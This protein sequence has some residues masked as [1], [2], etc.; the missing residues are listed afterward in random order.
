M[1]E[2]YAQDGS[3][4]S[5]DGI[6]EELSLREKA[7]QMVQVAL[8][9][10]DLEEIGWLFEEIGPG[11]CLFPGAEP[12][13]FDGDRIA[14]HLTRIREYNIEHSPA[15]IPIVVGVDAVH[16]NATVDGATVFPHNSGVSA[17]RDPELLYEASEST[18]RSLLE[19]GVGWNFSPSA[20]VLRDP[21][22][23][24]YYEGFSEDPFL[25]GEMAK[26][27]IEGYESAGVCSCL[28]HFAGYSVPENG[29]DRAMANVS[30]RDLRSHIFP[31]FECALQS[32]PASVMANSGS[33]NGL[34]VHASKW[35][36]TTML[37]EKFG[38][39]G[40][41]VSDWQDIA[42]MQELHNYV[43]TYRDGVEVGVNAGI[44]M[45]MNPAD[46]ERFVSL[47]V[48]LVES[49]RISESRIDDAVRNVLRFK[50]SVGVFEDPYLER[51][52]RDVRPRPDRA[53]ARELAEQSLT[54]LKNEAETLPL[55]RD[56][57]EIF[58]T[59]LETSDPSFVMG[60]WTLGWQGI[61]DGREIA[62][63]PD[64]TELGSCLER[65]LHSEATVTT[66]AL[67]FT[68]DADD[69]YDSYA[70]P[71]PDGIDRIASETDAV[72]VV[73]GEGP[74]AEDVGDRESIALPATQR[75]LVQKLAEAT[76]DDC[77][78]VGVLVT[79]RPRGTARTFDRL[80]ALLL[81]Y[82]PGT[83]GGEVIADALVGET[84]PSG[85]LPFTW[86]K[87]EG[88][89]PAYYNA[90]SDGPFEL[91]GLPDKPG[92]HPLYE[93][94]HGLSYTDFEYRDV[95]VTPDTV[96]DP[97]VRDMVT[98]TLTVE[99]TGERYGDR[100]VEVYAKPA[101]GD[102]IHPRRR[103]LGYDRIGLEAGECEKVAVPVHLRRLEVVPGDIL[104][105]EPKVV[106]AGE[107]ALEIGDQSSSLTILS[108]APAGAERSEG[109]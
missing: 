18:A 57:G 36:L 48:D 52:H 17:A 96:E 101:H 92:R 16:G 47:V 54:L 65:A 88:R 74:H 42:R 35:M 6:I 49:G 53:I 78:L 68:Q 51:P 25:T 66:N 63:S 73:L 67:T 5:V 40:L 86:P 89:L 97:S 7:G 98:V 27:K 109:I 80:D 39:E 30:M 12:P 13:I 10:F 55:G 85:R 41:L 21:R 94:G 32:E 31:P 9:T 99:N 79:G 34:P 33:V 76:A 28:K 75:R 100:V 70:I 45:V 19:M 64:H 4:F 46:P 69:N 95:T 37:R 93:F 26:A 108:S 8:N 22:W 91:S 15:G 106:E 3:H 43:S 72:I 50:S 82:L 58:L 62:A 29:R 105:T 104:G 90:R 1:N 83:M 84:N 102:V 2:E 77:P 14:G 103:L 20:D 87:N 59:G 56:V 11:A 61:G 81:A 38:F 71:D 24:R 107:Y 23:G 60:G 44:D